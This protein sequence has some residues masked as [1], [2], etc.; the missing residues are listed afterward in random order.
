M[1]KNC[2]KKMHLRFNFDRLSNAFTDRVLEFD[3]SKSQHMHYF[4]TIHLEK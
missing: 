4:V 2:D 1:I 3:A